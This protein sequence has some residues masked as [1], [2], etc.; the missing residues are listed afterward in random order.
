MPN[1]PAA[2]A[3]LDGVLSRSLARMRVLVGTDRKRAR[4][5]RSRTVPARFS[6][7][8]WRSLPAAAP[9]P[10]NARLGGHVARHG[11][12]LGQQRPELLALRPDDGNR[13]SPGP[14]RERVARSV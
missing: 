4:P 3:Q 12:Q 1:G 11:R 8:A 13:T 5:A 6:R 14:G 10:G 9:R 2:F 7:R